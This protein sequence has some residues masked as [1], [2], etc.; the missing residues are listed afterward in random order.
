MHAMIR[1]DFDDPTFGDFCQ[2]LLTSMNT[3]PHR[4]YIL[5]PLLNTFTRANNINTVSRLHI[6]S[7][8]F[9][10]TIS[11]REMNN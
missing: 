3:K 6:F 8:E 2:R 11:Y 5:V 10:N 9:E 1:Q 7:L 4:K